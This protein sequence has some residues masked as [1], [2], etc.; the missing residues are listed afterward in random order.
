M[1]QNVLVFACKPPL[2]KTRVEI[3][4]IDPHWERPVVLVDV[5][6]MRSLVRSAKV[7]V[8]GGG[9]Y[10]VSRVAL[11]LYTATPIDLCAA[12]VQ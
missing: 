5:E 6:L 7:F 1:T 9:C 4:E 8:A 12:R 11:F 10:T 3:D 2:R